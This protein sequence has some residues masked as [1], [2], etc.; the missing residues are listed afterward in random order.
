MRFS[1]KIRGFFCFIY[2]C[3]SATFDSL[4]PKNVDFYVRIYSRY[5]SYLANIAEEILYNFF[6]Y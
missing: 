6:L 2:L 3:C 5:I 4:R 1:D